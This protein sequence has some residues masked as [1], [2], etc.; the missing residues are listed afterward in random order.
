MWL[1]AALNCAVCTLQNYWDLH[2]K[3]VI[4]PYVAGSADV[5]K[6]LAHFKEPV[7]PMAERKW[8]LHFR[9]GC[10]PY[11]FMFPNQTK[12]VTGKVRAQPPEHVLQGVLGTTGQLE[13]PQMLQIGSCLMLCTH[14]DRRKATASFQY[15]TPQSPNACMVSILL[16]AQSRLTLLVGYYCSLP[17]LCDSAA[18]WSAGCLQVS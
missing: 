17:A 14:L 1:S 2:D 8:L 15:S 12:I 5:T 3:M 6:P 7:L 16:N 13:S 4:A 18:S 9:G 10:L 11:G